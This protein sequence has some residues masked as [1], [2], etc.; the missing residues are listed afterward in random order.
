VELEK[1]AHILRNANSSLDWAETL[2][3][4]GSAKGKNLLEILNNFRHIV[5]PEFEEDL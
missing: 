3:H 4:M 2:S 1:F 5:V